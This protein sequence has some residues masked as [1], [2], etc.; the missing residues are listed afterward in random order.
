MG[1]RRGQTACEPHRLVVNG[2]TAR[3]AKHEWKRQVVNPNEPLDALQSPLSRRRSR[4]Q[5]PYSSFFPLKPPG[6][7]LQLGDGD[8]HCGNRRT[9][10]HRAVARH[11]WIGVLSTQCPR[12]VVST[13]ASS[14]GILTLQ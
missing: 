3:R 11:P 5:V 14:S 4:V 6:G 12:R 13:R 2:W 1:T 10:C 8:G 7:S 9:P